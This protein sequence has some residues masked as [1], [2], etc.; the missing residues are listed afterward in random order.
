[1]IR[2]ETFLIVSVLPLGGDNAGV[3]LLGHCG[4]HAERQRQNT[5]QGHDS[6]KVLF[7]E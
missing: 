4:D 1:M 2:P 7:H 6:L 3:I 5:N